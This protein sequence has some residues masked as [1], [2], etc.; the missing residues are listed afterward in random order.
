MSARSR[1]LLAFYERQRIN[2]QLTFYRDRRDQLERATG[3]GLA[4]SAMLLSFASAAGALAGTTLEW[5]KLWTA[6][7]PILPAIATALSAYIAL[8][9]FEQQSKIYGDAVRAIR[10]ASH[11]LPDSDVPGGGQTPDEQVAELVGR[12]EA[13]MRQESAQWGQLTSRIQITERSEG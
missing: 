8:F 5:G 7:A 13:A 3:Q 1:E 2:D 6:L 9:A 12:V 11:P 10:T 4:V